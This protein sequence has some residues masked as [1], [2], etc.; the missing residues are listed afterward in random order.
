MMRHWYRFSREVVEATSL[1]TFKTTLTHAQCHIKVTDF[2]TTAV[3]HPATS[4]HYWNKFSLF[5]STHLNI[6]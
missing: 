4:K 5:A 6:S 1:E 2:H 3:S